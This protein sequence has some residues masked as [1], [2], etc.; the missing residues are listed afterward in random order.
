MQ[1]GSACFETITDKNGRVQSTKRT[2][3][4]RPVSRWFPGEISRF[5]YVEFV[6]VFCCNCCW[7]Q[8]VV[9]VFFCCCCCCLFCCCLCVMLL[10]F[11]CAFFVVVVV[12]LF[13]LFCF[14][15]LCVLFVV[16][17]VV[18]VFVIYFFFFFFFYYYFFWWVFVVF[19][20][21]FCGGGWVGWLLL[22]VLFSYFVLIIFLKL[23]SINQ[24]ER[25]K[26]SSSYSIFLS[27]LF[28]NYYCINQLS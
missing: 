27:S 21:Y 15:L 10:L 6:G 14:C 3:V 9:G 24:V 18:V 11:F 5:T 19:G 2:C 17:V 25:C 4:K 13:V 28:I 20:I 23:P 16:V 8:N 7:L 12:V 22:G 1:N 26:T